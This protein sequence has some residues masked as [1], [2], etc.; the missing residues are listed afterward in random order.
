MKKWQEFEDTGK[1]TCKIHGEHG[2]WAIYPDGEGHKRCQCRACNRDSVKAWNKRNP[3]CQS[4]YANSRIG[5]VNR[6]LSGARKRARD[7]NLP[8]DIDS[9]WMSSMLD[10]QDDKCAYSG[11]PFDWET[12]I[13]EKRYRLVSIDQR[14][15]GVGYTRDNAVLVCW[16]VNL[17]K[18]DIPLDEFAHLCSAVAEHL[19]LIMKL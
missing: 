6:S 19:A 14:I 11:L 2:D 10:A 9:F 17:M 5:I 3:E 15:P 8:F 13:G 16:G 7:K 12:P 18:Q 4:R 1:T